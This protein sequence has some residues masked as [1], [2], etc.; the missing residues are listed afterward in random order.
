MFEHLI[1][2]NPVYSLY[3]AWDEA[4]YEYQDDFLGYWGVEENEPPDHLNWDQWRRYQDRYWLSQ[5]LARGAYNLVRPGRLPERKRTLPEELRREADEWQGKVD[6]FIDQLKE[7]LEED[8]WR[9]LRQAVRPGAPSD[10]RTQHKF[11]RNCLEI[12]AVELWGINPRKMA[13]RMGDLLHY[14]IEDTG[15]QVRGYLSRVAECY[16]RGMETEF[17]VMCRAVL[18]AALEGVIP[19]E[20]L[21]DSDVI[22]VRYNEN[23]SLK[24]HID[25]AEKVGVLEPEARAKA[26][27]IRRIGNDAVH[28]GPEI[29]FDSASL[30][31]DLVFVVRG[32][33]EKRQ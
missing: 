12:E 5:K 18:E 26:G 33:E 3:D 6:E 16:V 13:E 1:S 31:E 29:D 17:A 15:P 22:E 28:E 23:L 21:S 7:E 24:K 30:L 2:Q 11:L 20:K 14:L 27:N 8:D 25:C 19:A 32:I 10:P 4:F 9:E